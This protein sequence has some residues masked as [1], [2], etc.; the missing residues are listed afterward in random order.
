[1]AGLMFRHSRNPSGLRGKRP[2]AL[3]WLKDFGWSLPDV[4]LYPTGGGTG[5]VGM[6][7]AFA[8]LETL[9]WIDSWRPRM[10]SVQA[11]GCAPV[12][13]AFQS[14]A[15][16]CEVWQNASTLASGLRVPAVFADRL[17]LKLCAK[18]TERR[19]L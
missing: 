14:N 13:K 8:E 10:V 6:W 18:A 11:D 16:R 9:G 19:S 7:K 17:I 5:L 4:I 15:A 3:N 1:M 12:V 2:W